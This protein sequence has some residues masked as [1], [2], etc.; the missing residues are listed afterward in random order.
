MIKLAFVFKTAP[1]GNA[2]SREG[3]DALLAATAFCDEQEIAVF[4][5]DDGVFNLIANQQP[6]R[7]L[8]KDFIST[9]KLLDLYDIE[10]RFVCQQSLQ[11]NGL[12]QTEFIIN[13]EKIDRSLL[14]QKLKS[15][16]QILTF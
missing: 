2:I 7:I 4:F 8:Q 11:E 12:S 3:L 5:L 14:V 16:V 9:F 1:H 15:A 6:E 13:C 10:N